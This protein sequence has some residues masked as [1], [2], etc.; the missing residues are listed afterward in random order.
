[1]EDEFIYSNFIYIYIYVVVTEK[2]TE[3]RNSQNR[4]IKKRK[5]RY[6]SET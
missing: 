4:K 1:M 6:R 5:K 2:L 3:W